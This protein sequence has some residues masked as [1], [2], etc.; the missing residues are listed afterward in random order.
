MDEPWSSLAGLQH[1]VLARSQ[2]YALG[3]TRA[4]VRA[5]VSAGRWCWRTES[6]LTTTTGP[7]NWEQRLWL[8]VLHCGPG[9][10]V[11]GLTA[12]KVHGLRNWDRDLVT[13]VVDDSLSFEKV[14]ELHIVRTRRPIQKWLAPVT[15]PLLRLEPAVLL[16]GAYDRSKRTAQGALAAVVQQG[17]TTPDR[18]GAC[19]ATMNPLRRSRDFRATLLDLAG[20][21]QSVAE[22]DVR[23]ACRSYGVVPPHR[24]RARVDRAG[25]RRWTDC[26]WDLPDG[27]VVVLEVDGAFHLDVMQ[28]SAD[29]R[30]QRRITTPT[31][32]IVRCAAVEIRDEPGK[33]MADL[34]ALGVPLV[35]RAG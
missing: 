19:L 5:N 10:A 24:Q 8:G 23:R 3:V 25:K 22:M 9:S 21:A 6:V 4:A 33:V 11:G 34:I 30:R 27:R 20:G 7:L 26:E 2:L 16:F 1:G 18:L 31:R 15:L 14:P 17:L 12:A 28:Y 35:K 32:L 29:M 13:V